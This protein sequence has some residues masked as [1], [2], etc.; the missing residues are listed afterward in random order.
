MP[1]KAI[2]FLPLYFSRDPVAV[3]AI[4]FSTPD[5]VEFQWR[6]HNYRLILVS[7]G[8]DIDLDLIDI[9]I[10]DVVDSLQAAGYEV[11][12]WNPDIMALGAVALIPS[13][14]VAQGDTS[15]MLRVHTSILHSLLGGV[16][17]ERDR[18][19]TDLPSAIDQIT[20]T[21]ASQ[22]WLDRHG[23]VYGVPRP[24]GM[25]D[26]GYLQHILD[27]V[28]RARDNPVGM[29][30]NIRRLLGH[31]MRIF[32]PWRYIARWSK[33]KL[34]I[35]QRFEDDPFWIKNVVQLRAH[36]AP[37]SWVP[38]MAIAQ[39]DRPAGTLLFEP[40]WSP[41]P[42]V[43]QVDPQIHTGGLVKIW[44]YH[45]RGL[46]HLRHDYSR[47]SVDK[48]AINYPVAWV[49]YLASECLGGVGVEGGFTID[50]H[51]YCWNDAVWSY[52]PRLGDAECLFPGL[53]ALV[54]TGD[55]VRFSDDAYLSDYKA[56]RERVPICRATE[57][58][59]FDADVGL[60]GD[61]GAGYYAIMGFG[62][63]LESQM[64]RDWTVGGWDNHA[65]RDGEIG[66]RHEVL[67]V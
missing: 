40:Q 64:A 39:A 7:P 2:D 37:R 57:P 46:W 29:E 59:Q 24:E 12:W 60:V 25:D 4:A 56:T 61:I 14:G 53:S 10:G 26:A 36:N 27:E 63:A 30:S 34:S 9:V 8:R 33:S 38:S 49:T 18:F 1:A 47:A 66:F 22:Y 20:L 50:R 21:T 28:Q 31:D 19:E 6:V 43:V 44:S 54:I 17:R 62:V 13:S 32:E 16:E 3:D 15:G 45:V 48:P 58:R 67:D 65:W 55:Q 51:Q 42:W 5:R 35:D 52:G 11:T 23:Q 41:L